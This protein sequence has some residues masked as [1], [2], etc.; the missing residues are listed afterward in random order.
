MN[1]ISYILVKRAVLGQNWKQAGNLF[2]PSPNAIIR[3]S[4]S[5]DTKKKFSV[6]LSLVS[7]YFANDFSIIF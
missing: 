1:Q 3:E 5:R 4:R 6:D 2:L 7:K